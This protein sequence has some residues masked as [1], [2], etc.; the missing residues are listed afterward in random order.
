MKEILEEA[1]WP[2]VSVFVAARNEEDSIG[3]CLSALQNQRYPG[4]WEVWVANDHSTD[5]TAEI[6][7]SFCAELSH[8]NML[9]VPDA[10]T[11][12]KGK[13]FALGLM[14]EKAEG[15]I[16]LVCD[17]DMEMPGDWILS[18]IQEMKSQN[19]DLMNGTT[20]TKGENIFSVLQGIDWL[21]PQGTFAWMSHLN[22]TYT[23]MGNN[24]AISR[25][26]YEATGGYLK[27]PFSLTEDFELFKHAR[28]K[29]F[30]LIHYFNKAVLGYSEPEK[31]VSDWL[32]QHVR[33]MVGFMQLPF[34]QQWV[35]YIQLLFY[36]LFFV[37]FFFEKSVATEIAQCLFLIKMV[38]EACLLAVVGR[39]K[40]IFWL[41]V[42]QLVWWPF[43]MTC[44]FRFHFSKTIVWK[45]RVW[46]K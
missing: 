20:T 31:T 28:E 12:V 43:Y 27:L 17:A 18:M 34:S 25:K 11:H 4:H 2:S 19:V 14:A 26:A 10:D 32:S 23:A 8:F 24:M 1:N 37:S 13:A 5:T 39:W 3:K 16:F 30:R 45:D 29:G 46:E 21:L 7:E 33:W 9:Q 6:V 35:F 22:I 40:F 41:P 44:F 15:E 36:P 38:Y 42:Y